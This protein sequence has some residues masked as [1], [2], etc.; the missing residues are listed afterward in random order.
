MYA[1]L[2]G[3]PPFRG[4]TVQETLQLVRSEIPKPPRTLNPKVDR[5]LEAIC[6]KCLNKD[7][8]Q[9]YASA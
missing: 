2:T 3:K 6:L 1:L 9:R 7:K 5:A 4:E 8:V